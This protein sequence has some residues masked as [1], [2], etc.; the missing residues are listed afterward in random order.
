MFGLPYNR[1]YTASHTASQLFFGR[2]FGAFE[3]FVYFDGLALLLDRAIFV[4]H[5]LA[6][7][8]QD[9]FAD[10]FGLGFSM[11]WHAESDSGHGYDCGPTDFDDCVHFLSLMSL[12]IRSCMARAQNGWGKFQPTKAPTAIQN[13]TSSMVGLLRSQGVVAVPVRQR[14]E[15]VLAWPP[16]LQTPVLALVQQV[17]RSWGPEL[18]R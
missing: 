10:F 2:Y 12:V 17:R 14:P 18:V 11:G 8:V 5:R 6:L 13:K 1:N 3:F 16:E 9:V 15:L 7:L 4:F